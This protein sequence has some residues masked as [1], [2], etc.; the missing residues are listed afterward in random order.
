VGSQPMVLI[1]SLE[2]RVQDIEDQ[3]HSQT[4][5]IAGLTF[6]SQLLTRTWMT[7]NAPAAGAYIY[8]FD[9]H[10][11]PSLA[12]DEADTTQ[13]V[14]NFSHSAAKGGYASSEEAQVAASFKIALPAI[15]GSDSAS[16]RVSADTQALPAFKVFEIWDPEDG[17][18][19]A[20]RRFDEQIKEVKATMLESVGDHLVGIGC[21]VAMECIQTTY[22]FLS[23]LSEW[24]SRQYKS[25]VARGGT[26]EAC[27][28]LIC[29]RVRAIFWD[30]HKAR[31]AGRG[32][33]L[34]SDRASGIMWGSLQAHRLMQE[35]L[36]SDFS[37]HPKCSHILNIHLHD[38]VLMKADY[39]MDMDMD[40]VKARVVDLEKNLADL[41]A[42]HDQLSTKV[43]KLMGEDTDEDTVVLEECNFREDLND[44]DDDL[45]PGVPASWRVWPRSR[46]RKLS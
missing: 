35:Y 42:L 31:I 6:K 41:H 1:K 10:G 36:M 39:K 46:S 45:D 44:L 23:K 33:F 22:A 13:A 27:W 25:L 29:H 2:A 32:S 18:T 4:V 38:N 7:T 21:M 40:K 20:K 3:L 9:A 14:L 16:T 43:G 37:A 28:G 5:M 8:F 12:A 11:M 17:Y 19:G 15:F 34:G 26:K 30:L 24:M